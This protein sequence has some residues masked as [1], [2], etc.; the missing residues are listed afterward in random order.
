MDAFRGAV[1]I[2]ATISMGLMAGVFGLYAHTIMPGLR[3]TDDRTFVAAYQALDRAII[4]PWFMAGGFLG[5]LVLT[6]LAAVLHLA[7]G[8]GVVLAWVL[9]AFVLYLV[10]V[11]ITFAVNLP[12]NDGLKAAG[13]PDGIP[14]LA[15]VRKR[16]NESRWARWNVARAL[17][18]TAAV[19]CLA[20]ALVEHGRLS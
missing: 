17:L 2:A 4:N 11:V 10:T 5:A 13:D 9:A 16:F 20:W 15:A 12:L 6:G 7:G 8:H 14:D 18:S 3:G 1:L 19:G